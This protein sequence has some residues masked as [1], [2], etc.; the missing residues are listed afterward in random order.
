MPNIRI[1]QNNEFTCWV[2]KKIKALK[3]GEMRR[4][5]TNIPPSEEAKAEAEECL[6]CKYITYCT[7]TSEGKKPWLFCLRYITFCTIIF[8]CMLNWTKKKTFLQLCQKN[9][10]TAIR[11][12]VYKKKMAFKIEILTIKCV[13]NHTKAVT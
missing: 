3:N 11:F 13:A 8:I 5:E 10:L 1:Q 4:V 12:C 6:L 7:N 9:S 2:F